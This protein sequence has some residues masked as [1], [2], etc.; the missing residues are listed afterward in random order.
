[1]KPRRAHLFFTGVSSGNAGDDLMFQG[2]VATGAL[3]AGSTVEV[4]DASEEALRFLPHHFC[5]L[6]FRDGNARREALARAELALV[7]GDTPVMEDWGLAWPLQA[8]A[9]SVPWASKAGV[10]LHVVGVGADPLRSSEGRSLFRTAFADAR[11]FTVRDEPSRAALRDLGVE[12][13]RIVVAADLAWLAPLPTERE[14]GVALAERRSLGFVDGEIAV[15]VCVVNERWPGP[16][17]VKR[18]IARALDALHE[19]TGARTAFLST[20]SRTEDYFDDAAARAVASF[21]RSPVVTFPARRRAPGEIEALLG[22]FPVAL[23]Q[24]YH[25]TILAIRAGAATVSFARGHKLAGLLEE[26]GEEPVGTMEEVDAEVLTDRLRAAVR[27]RSAA[28]RRAS[29]AARHLTARARSATFFLEAAPPRKEARL[30]S[31]AELE[32]DRFRGFMSLV[33]G[34]AEPLGL[35]VM[36]DWSKVWEYPWLWFHGLAEAMR[37]DLALLDMGSERTSIP[38]FLASLGATV[39]LVEVNDGSVAL[40]EEIRSRTK[41][42][43][44]WRIVSGSRLPF[45]DAAFDVVTSFSVVE[46]QDDPALAIA[47]AARVLKPGGLLAISFDICEPDRGMTF[48]SWNG[49]ALTAAE[50]TRIAWES[51]LFGRAPAA[52]SWNWEDEAAFRA[53]N[54]KS[55]PHHN[56]IA[57]A[58][59]LYRSTVPL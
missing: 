34:F 50:F 38:W 13:D 40:W 14:R 11:S 22:T 30:A 58:A 47:E 42:S 16:T 15:A 56:Y 1:M 6:D 31:V 35:R 5:Y 49:R 23:S 12:E 51:P 4:L 32:S 46:H 43:V 26:L 41:L 45:P 10:P 54:L 48:P 29:F 9:E 33:N 25:F 57:G 20:E 7:A 18:S 2:L 8:L 53:W 3:A 27:E 52:P 39:T 59:V 44:D 55:A 19:E 36:A 37:P 17:G 28:A 24:R 21:M